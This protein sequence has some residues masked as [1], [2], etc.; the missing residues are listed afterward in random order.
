[1]PRQPRKI[2]K[3]DYF[4]A[5]QK[6]PSGADGARGWGK[7]NMITLG[8]TVHKVEGRKVSIKS[9]Q[10]YTQTFHLDKA[11]N[12]VHRKKKK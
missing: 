12:I 8:G 2:S 3:G 9:R 10:G 7:E 4:K 11:T 5:T 1:M 6:Y